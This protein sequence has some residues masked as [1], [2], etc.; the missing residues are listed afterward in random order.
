MRVCLV[1]PPHNYKKFMENLVIVN[2]E[3]GIF[4]PLG[5]M[6]VAAILERAGH[7]VIIIDSSAL[8]LSKK[9]TLEKIKRFNPNILGFLLTTWMFRQTLEWISYLKRKINVPVIVGNYALE[10]YPREVLSHSEIDFGIIGSAEKSLPKLIDALENGNSFEN[11]EGLGF[12]K[13]GKII[14]NYPKILHGDLNNLP[15]P[16]RHLVPNKKY[17]GFYSQKKNFTIMVT[18]KGCSH[19]CTFCD[20]GKTKF[21]ARN[22]QN[23]VDEIEKCFKKFGVKEIDFFDRSFTADKKRVIDICRKIR[24]RGIRISWSCRARVDEVDE[25]LLREMKMAGCRL[26]LYGIESGDQEILDKEHK[27]ITK[28][29]IRETINLTKKYGIRVQGFFMIGQP[30]D[31]KETVEK[32]LQFAKDLNIDYAQFMRTVAKPGAKLY[33]DVSKELGY[34]YFSSY[35]LGEVPEMRLPTPWTELSEKEIDLLTRKAYLGFYFRPSY[36]LKTILRLGSFEELMRY[37]RAGLQ[38]ILFKSIFKRGKKI[39]VKF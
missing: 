17:A 38:M 9:R 34:D 21:N 2:E 8:E 3:F 6:Y 13:N 30:G 29:R 32:T 1:F 36:I 27:G 23:V 12:K 4:P 10:Q 37:V 28:D 35:I 18:S 15:F 39:L 16:A 7:D 22:P 31:T 20:M 26:I 19:Q 14:I 24:K 5:L 33:E 25:E 11:I